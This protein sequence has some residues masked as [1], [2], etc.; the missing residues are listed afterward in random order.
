MNFRAAQDIRDRAQGTF[1]LDL[2]HISP[3]MMLGAPL[4]GKRE[5]PVKSVSF[6]QP[7]AR[8]QGLTRKLK[9]ENIS[10]FPSFD[11]FFTVCMLH[12][13]RKGSLILHPP[14]GVFYTPGNLTFAG[15]QGHW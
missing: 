4:S 14:V 6:A 7:S 11:H 15:F 8:H 9:S 12:V 1:C 10:V 2:Q 13:L 3:L 5:G